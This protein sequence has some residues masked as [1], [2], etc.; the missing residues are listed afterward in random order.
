[1]TLGLVLSGLFF[2]GLPVF[3]LMGGGWGKDEPKKRLVARVGGIVVGLVFIPCY[4]FLLNFILFPSASSLLIVGGVALFLS[5]IGVVLTRNIIVI[6]VLLP[7]I[8]VGFSVIY[9]KIVGDE[10]LPFYVLGIASGVIALPFLIVAAGMACKNIRGG[11]SGNNEEKTIEH[12][13]K[14]GKRTGE[15]KVRG[16][17]IEHRNEWGDSV[18]ESR[19][20]GNRIEHRDR[21]GDNAGE[22]R[23]RGKTIEL[24]DSRG[25][26]I[27]T[28]NMRG[29][30]IEHRDVEG[31]DKGESKIR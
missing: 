6:W 24:Y 21:W 19:I 30:T 10:E 15:S 14:W 31:R 7:L 4:I 25:N 8:G 23:I 27:G 11:S 1:M 5:M 13:D 20:K 9:G 3:L 22:S 29:D 2:I 28:S 18:G 26:R 12:Y 16:N 17:K